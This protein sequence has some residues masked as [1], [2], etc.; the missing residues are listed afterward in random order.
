MFDDTTIA[1]IIMQYDE[2]KMSQSGLGQTG[3]IKPGYD[4]SIISQILI[5]V[6]CLMGRKRFIEPK[7]WIFKAF[8]SCAVANS[9][10]IS[11]LFI[12]LVTGLVVAACASAPLSTATAA[13]PATTSPSESPAVVTPLPTLTP[14]ETATETATFTAEPPTA[15]PT[16]A[17]DAACNGALT[18]V[19]PNGQWVFC[20]AKDANSLSIPYAVT[21]A[22]S[23]GR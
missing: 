16:S 10:K 1:P 7:G 8:Q 4:A 13:V 14:V 9:N 23:A 12:A 15:S 2:K 22:A 3:H 6:R 11:L 20:D 19:S 5:G 21:R 18:S 17:L